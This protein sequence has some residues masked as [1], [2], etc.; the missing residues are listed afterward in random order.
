M[1]VAII[2]YNAGNI[3]SVKYALERLGVSTIITDNPQEITSADKVIFPGVG[4]AKSAMN[5]L[6]ENNLVDLIKNL[7]QP[8]LGICI[9]QQLLCNSSEEGNTTCMGVFPIAVKRFPNGIKHREETLKIPHMGWNSIDFDPSFPLFKNLGENPYVYYVHSY[10]SDLHPTY[11]I[12]TTQYATKYS[13]ALHKDNFYAV[14]FHPE[15]SGKVGQQIL[16]NFL[17]L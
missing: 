1:K 10:C 14:Q 8:V 13:A 5:Y 4:E 3:Q 17:E 11:T 2:K 16:Q 9:G 15:K 6:N 7:K 12:A